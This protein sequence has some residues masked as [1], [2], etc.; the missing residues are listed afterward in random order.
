MHHPFLIGDTVYLRGLEDADLSGPYFQWFNDAET[1]R[2]NSHATFPNTVERMRERFAEAQQSR[3]IVVFA[4]VARE[5]E[6]HV[7]TTSLQAIDWISRSAEIAFLIGH[8]HGGRGYGSAAG[9]MLL[10]YAFERLNLQRIHCGT[11]AENVAMQKLAE[12]LGMQREGIRRKA[13]YKFGKY[14]DLYEY[15]MLRDEW[16]G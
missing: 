4:I 9:Q 10:R 15:G 8:E 2:S 6:Q 14:L 13:M 16:H 12:K 5:G 7:G 3:D 1:S 11:S